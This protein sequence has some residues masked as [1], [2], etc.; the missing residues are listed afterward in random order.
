MSSFKKYGIDPA[1]YLEIA[2][3]K[4]KKAGYDPALLE[5]SENKKYKL[6]YDNIFFGSH[7]YADFIIYSILSRIGEDP[8]YTREYAK[9]KRS[10]Y[11][12]RSAKIRGDWKSDLLSP[13]NLARNIIW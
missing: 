10:A 3:Y 2:K 13:N 5:L 9:T 7:P 6:S 8:I 12:E 4:A 11:L 1:M